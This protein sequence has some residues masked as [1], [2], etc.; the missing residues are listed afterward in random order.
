MKEM[1]SDRF[2][3]RMRQFCKEHEAY[4]ARE[5][6]EKGASQRL[7]KIHLEK[8]RWL[9]HERLIHLLVVIMTVLGELFSILLLLDHP[10]T[11]PAAAFLAL[12]LGVL[13][14]FYFVH[15]FFLENTTQ[16]WYRIAE[17]IMERLDETAQPLR[18][19]G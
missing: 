2:G 1:P 18:K 6:A 12:V 19:E 9:Q 14:G 3:V 15:Y 17:T 4:V 11:N 13:L 7:L 10:E 8:L 16:H 5:L